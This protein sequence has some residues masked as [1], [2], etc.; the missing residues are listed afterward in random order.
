MARAETVTWLPLDDWAKIIGISPLAFNGLDSPLMNNNVCG[1][2]FFQWDWQ[3]SSRIGR[4]T[5]A[6][7][8]HEAEEEMALEAG[9]DLMP[10]WTTEE[11]LEYPKPSVPGMYNISGTNPRGMLKSVE[12]RKAWIISGGIKTKTLIGAGVVFARSDNDGDGYAETCTAIVPVT[13]TDTNEIHVYYSSQSGDDSWEIRPIK[14]SI[15][16]GNATIVFKAWQVVVA[17]SLDRLDAQ[18]LDAADPASY[19][20]TIDVYRVYNDPSTQVQLM[21]ENTGFN[22]CGTCVACQFGTQAGCFHL[23]DARLGI[24]VPAPGS[25]NA[26]NQTFDSAVWSNCREPDQLRL[27]YY[28]GYTDLKLARPYAE[29]SPYWKDAIAYFSVSKFARPLCGCDNVS[30]FIDKWRRDA[31][32]ASQEEGG[33]TVTAELAANKLGTALG[34]LYAYR[35]IHRNGMRINK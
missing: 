7:A 35:Q 29:L 9:F 20:I 16:G 4:E 8:I 25:W 30:N 12:A 23:R 10:D 34:A 32:F 13:I 21:W 1:E 33:F 11:R 28:S 27:W 18:P 3:H 15:S 5:I 14:V 22:C 31:S 6:R 26:S 19:E 2:I 17:A 24:L